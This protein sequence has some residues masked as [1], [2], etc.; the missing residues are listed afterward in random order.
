MSKWDN[1]GQMSTCMTTKSSSCCHLHSCRTAGLAARLKVWVSLGLPDS[2]A[3][4]IT[5]AWFDSRADH[6]CVDRMEFGSDSLLKWNLGAWQGLLFKA[7]TVITYS[8]FTFSFPRE[9]G[10]KLLQVSLTPMIVVSC[11]LCFS[12]SSSDGWQSNFYVSSSLELS[13]L[14]IY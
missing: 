4:C 13:K 9:V 7:D 10:V 3:C 5:E 1:L 2:L 14:C 8:S 6:L 12:S 11:S